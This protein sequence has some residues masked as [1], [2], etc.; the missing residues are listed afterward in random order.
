MEVKGMKN[1]IKR[2]GAAL[3]LC[4]VAFNVFAIDPPMN[5]IPGE[6]FGIY[7]SGNK[8][9]EKLMN[10]SRDVRILV[11]D[12]QGVAFVGIAKPE[13]DAVGQPV[14]LDYNAERDDGDRLYVNIGTATVNSGLYDWEIVP[15]ARYANGNYT[16]AVTFA[17]G[18]T[19]NDD[20]TLKETE[21]AAKKEVKNLFWIS[22]HPDLGNT[23]VGYNLFLV[24]AMLTGAPIN[25]KIKNFTDRSKNDTFP[26]I[27]GY[28]DYDY[29]NDES[30]ETAFVRELLEK[31]SY[32][33]MLCITHG[34][35]PTYIYSDGNMPIT[36]QLNG[37][38]VEFTGYPVYHDM[39]HV[40]DTWTLTLTREKNVMPDQLK[41]RKLDQ[42]LNRMLQPQVTVT[43]KLPPNL[44]ILGVFYYLP[45]YDPDASLKLRRYYDMG[46]EIENTKTKVEKNFDPIPELVD[47]MSTKE[48]YEA[49]KLVN[50]VVFNSA[51]RTCH[52][53][54]FFRSV[55]GDHE[56]KTAEWESFIKA[57]N[58]R[59]PEGSEDP[60]YSYETPRL[61][62]AD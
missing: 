15:I 17:G 52:W 19:D 59:Y 35:I 26:V 5:R 40:S 58:A 23:L 3:L 7:N 33:Y 27:K 42:K 10:D 38:K 14:S 51:E 13:G 24:D 30:T 50:P 45:Q 1:L 18:A 11:R 28:N 41:E 60:A 57:V 43:V 29:T 37:G 21:E 31:R 62:I 20:K 44:T 4:L 32:H 36:Y 47:F 61:W 12:T 6:A 22:Y 49:M 53:L 48:S 2:I 55:K 8:Q 9:F 39:V 25:T 56:N 34:T 54:A 46:Y 16:S